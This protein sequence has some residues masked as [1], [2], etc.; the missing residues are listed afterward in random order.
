MPVIPL[1]VLAA[2]LHATWNAMVKSADDRLATM[3]VIGLTSV[4]VC[5]PVALLAPTPHARSLPF[6]LASVCTHGIYSLTLINCYR[7]SDF[8]Q[9]YPIARGI[10]PPTVAIAAAVFVGEQLSFVQVLGLAVLTSG[11]LVTAA[12][13]G[14]ASRRAVARAAFCGL[15]IATY[16]VLDGVGVRRSGASL[17]YTGWLFVAEGMIVPL[18]W[19]AR[20]R[21]R[22][23]Q[24]RV[25]RT[26]TFHAVVAGVLSVLAYSLVLWAQTHGALAIVAALR[27]T[28][29][30]FGAM[31]GAT[32]FRERMPSRRVAAAALIASGAVILAAG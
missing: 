29:V 2:G 15:S 26:V 20:R 28:S 25:S 6:L 22:G 10:A 31:I 19:L 27:E 14:H 4:V 23:V 9:V 32:V 5:L 3:S 8:N 18:V 13:R 30:V 24:L 7:D 16:T 12:G 11:M 17:G 21:V 1:V